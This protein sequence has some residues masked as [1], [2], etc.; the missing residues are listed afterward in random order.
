MDC[1]CYKSSATAEIDDAKLT[2]LSIYGFE[3]HINYLR[4]GKLSKTGNLS[5]YY[6]YKIYVN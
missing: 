3:I 6:Q 4:C 1:Y 2:F 5:I